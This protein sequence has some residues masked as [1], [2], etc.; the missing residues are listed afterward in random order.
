[1]IAVLHVE[2]GDKERAARRRLQRADDI[3]RR[4]LD[5]R[6]RPQQR[7]CRPCV[8]DQP[9]L[10]LP[11]VH[12]EQPVDR[13]GLLREVEHANRVHPPEQLHKLGVRGPHSS[14]RNSFARTLRSRELEQ[15]RRSVR[16]TLLLGQQREK[17][18][19]G[20]GAGQRDA[21]RNDV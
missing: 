10:P 19:A 4:Q 16:R 5:S 21:V 3:R 11:L 6:A 14:V 12:G 8:Q 13:L 18:C 2:F 1:V 9:L 7:V 20:R 15:T 17:V